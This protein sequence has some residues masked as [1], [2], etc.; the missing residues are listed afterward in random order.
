M[1]IV[2]SMA[3]IIFIGR[4]NLFYF[5]KSFCLYAAFNEII[6]FKQGTILTIR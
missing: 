3:S 1:S 4:L 5:Q 6:S 2:N